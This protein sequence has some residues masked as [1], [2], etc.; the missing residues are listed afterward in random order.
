MRIDIRGAI[1]NDGEQ[2]IYDWFD[3]PATSA[4]YVNNMLNQLSE[5]EDIDLYINSGG[6]AVFAGSEIYTNLRNHTSKVNVYIT[7]LAASAASVI[8]MAGDKIAMSPTAQIMIHNASLVAGGDKNDI[9][10]ALGLLS[11]TDEAIALAYMDRTN[12]T[13]EEILELM[14][15]ETWM[16]AISAKE[17]NFIDEVMFENSNNLKNSIANSDGTL[18]FE[19]I[20]K[21]RNEKDILEKDK[22]SQRGLTD[23]TE[24]KKL[25]LAK[26]R[27]YARINLLNKK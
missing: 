9:N 20:N 14:N 25:V 8:A 16:N 6:G 5:G 19:V 13:K 7:G 17:N 24:D 12:K 10:S 21:M 11:S 23:E 15:N 26:K 4:N 18:P 3:I 22:L 27:A 2:W 1:I